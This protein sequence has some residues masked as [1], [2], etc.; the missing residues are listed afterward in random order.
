MKVV[1]ILC[2]L[3]LLGF[4]QDYDKVSDLNIL[5]S[6]QLLC[7]FTSTVQTGTGCIKHKG[8]GNIYKVIDGNYFYKNIKGSYCSIQAEQLTTNPNVENDSVGEKFIETNQTNLENYE[9]AP[10]L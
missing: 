6:S 2:F 3:P 8:T 1:L 9:E 10:C 5:W 4:S 7:Q